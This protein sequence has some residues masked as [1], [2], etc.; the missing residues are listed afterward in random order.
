[1]ETMDE[2]ENVHTRSTLR[3]MTSPNTSWV[4]SKGV[5][6]TYV[7]ILILSRVLIGVVVPLSQDVLWT[8]WN[9]AHNV[10][11][12]SF[13]ALSPFCLCLQRA[14]SARFPTLRCF[15]RQRVSVFSACL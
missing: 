3:K 12:F 1:M 14:A 5:W 6:P 13:L 8:V 4:R 9:V 11:R 15:V 10:V 2:P 7:L